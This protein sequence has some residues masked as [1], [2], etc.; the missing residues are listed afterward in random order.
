MVLLRLQK[1]K[2][3]RIHFVVLKK[4]GMTSAPLGAGAD[5]S[6]PDALNT[7]GCRTL[8]GQTISDAYPCGGDRNKE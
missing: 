4:R 2:T 5:S 8:L 1:L 7:A 3:C 6:K